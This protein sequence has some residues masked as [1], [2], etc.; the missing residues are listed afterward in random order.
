LLG[1]FLNLDLLKEQPVSEELLKHRATADGFAALA[2]AGSGPNAEAATR[3][4][5]V[6]DRLKA[7]RETLSVYGVCD[8]DMV[9]WVVED[10]WVETLWKS[11]DHAQARKWAD[12]LLS[13]YKGWVPSFP[14]YWCAQKHLAVIRIRAAGFL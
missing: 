3:L 10:A 8:G 5:A 14:E 9:V 12:E 7:T 4:K 6:R 1:R 2:L 13:A 11:G